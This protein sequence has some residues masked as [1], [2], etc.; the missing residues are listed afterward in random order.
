MWRQSLTKKVWWKCE[1]GH[2]WEASIDHIANRGCNCPYCKNKKV[3]TGFNDLATIRPDLLDEWDYEKNKDIDPTMIVPGTAKKAWW[4]CK[5]CGY[6]WYT[7][8]HL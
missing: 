3:L 8:V 2:E 4:I 6:S 1:L 7:R 5:R